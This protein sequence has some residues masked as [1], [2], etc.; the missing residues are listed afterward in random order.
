VCAQYANCR[1]DGNTT[2]SFPF[3][4]PDVSTIDYFHPSQQGQTMLA[5]GTYAAGWNW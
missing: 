3:E 5:L 4:L 2:F 1:F